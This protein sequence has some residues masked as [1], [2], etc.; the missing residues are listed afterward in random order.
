[1]QTNTI[2]AGGIARARSAIGIIIIHKQYTVNGMKGLR[3]LFAL[4]YIFIR[5]GR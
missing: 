3:P 1:M 4:S 5:V 2:P